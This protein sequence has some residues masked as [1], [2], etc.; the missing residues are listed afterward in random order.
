MMFLSRTLFSLVMALLL[1]DVAIDLRDYEE[2][3]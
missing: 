3:I 2:L 1:L